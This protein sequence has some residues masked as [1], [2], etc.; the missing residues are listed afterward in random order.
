MATTLLQKYKQLLIDL[1]PPGRLWDVKNQPQLA[2]LLETTA[3]EFC[4][5]D[6]RARDALKE[7]D[8][9]ITQELL[10]DW[11]RLLN[12]PDECSPTGITDDERRTQIVEKYTDVGGL[13]KPFYEFL[14]AQLGFPSTVTDWKLFQVGRSKVGDPLTNDFDIPFEVGRSTVGEQLRV[15]GWLFYFNVE[16][17]IDAADVFEVGNNQVGDPLRSFSNPLIECTI[18]KLKPAH[19]GVTFSF[20]P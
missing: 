16:M 20:K 3:T 19:T 8:P 6:G 10:L 12:L 18:K 7:V 14:T 11:E 2:E 15:V 5:V 9:R 1:L 4:R 17:P 13:S